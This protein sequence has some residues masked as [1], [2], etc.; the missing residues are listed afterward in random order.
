[1]ALSSFPAFSR[2]CTPSGGRCFL[3]FLVSVLGVCLS[4]Y[5]H[6]TPGI[7]FDRNLFAALGMI[8]GAFLC[9]LFLLMPYGGWIPALICAFAGALFAPATAAL[10]G[11]DFDGMKAQ[12]E[13][14]ILGK[15]QWHGDL[16]AAHK[17][18][19]GRNMNQI[20]G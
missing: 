11:L 15:P 20:G 10:K 16:D 14:A 4:V 2:K 17:S 12:L 5:Y 13:A 19:A 8:P 1:M 3:V 18:G 6:F 7:P 9:A